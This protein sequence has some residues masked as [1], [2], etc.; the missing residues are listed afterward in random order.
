MT[1]DDIDFEL[2]DKT[3]A[4]IPAHAWIQVRQAI[5]TGLVDCMPGSVI[6]RITGTYDDFDQAEHILHLYYSGA[7]EG[8]KEL[9]VDGF[10]IM[11]ALNCIELLHSLNITEDG[12]PETTTA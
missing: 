9:L 11:G 4:L 1:Q 8:N 2:V 6:E 7:E 10:K 12:I 3:L 5:V